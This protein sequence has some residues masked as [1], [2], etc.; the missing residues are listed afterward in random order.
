MSTPA[1]QALIFVDGTTANT[2]SAHCNA[3]DRAFAEMGLDWVW[4]QTLY[5]ELLN[6]SGGKERI[7][8]CWQTSQPTPSVTRPDSNLSRYENPA[9]SL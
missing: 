5:I 8:H 9:P 3:V 1:Q 2:K 4:D 7:R 6:I